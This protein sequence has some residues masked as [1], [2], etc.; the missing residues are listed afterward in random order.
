MSRTRSTIYILG[1][2]KFKDDNIVID[3]LR[4]DAIHQ[5]IVSRLKY[6][7]AGKT[8]GW[9]K[10]N[11]KNGI[12]RTIADITLEKKYA[13]LRNKI[14]VEDA[15]FGYYHHR[16][17]TKYDFRIENYCFDSS[18]LLREVFHNYAK[19]IMQ[20]IV[21]LNQD[22]MLSF[23]SYPI[24]IVY[25]KKLNKSNRRDI[26]N[27]ETT[28]LSFNIMEPQWWNPVGKNLRIRI[29]IP[30]TIIYTKNR[31]FYFFQRDLNYFIQRDLIN[32]TY[33]YA[34]Y[35]K[36]FEDADNH[37]SFKNTLTE[38]ILVNLYEHILDTMGGRANDKFIA[39]V[40]QTNYFIALLA[41]IIT[42]F[43]VIIPLF[44]R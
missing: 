32:A 37:L 33:E 15:V 42:T 40:T 1:L 2:I 35:Q 16:I 41:L 11:V 18:R 21:N 44:T 34:L 26:F 19:D 3:N 28:S 6:T 29:S 9:S 17:I 20:A 27:E 14:T 43:T 39:K 24:I 22:I 7:P 36:K 8:D 10:Y 25:N 38:P 31:L 12:T 30:G 13:T 23:Y 5:S 4:L